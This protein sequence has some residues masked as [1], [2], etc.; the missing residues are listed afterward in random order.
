MGRLTFAIPAVIFVAIAAMFAIPFA[1]DLDPSKLPSALTDQPAP[2]FALPPVEG[3]PDSLGLSTADLHGQPSVVNVF[4]SWCLP[5]LAEHPIISRLAEEGVAVYGINH[6]DAAEDANRWLDR[7]G[8][9]YH[10][11]GADI[12]A[13]TSID[14]GVTGVPETFIVD[15]QGRVRHKIIGPMTPEIL[16]D[17]IMPLLRELNK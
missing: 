4:A 13:R 8:N 1:L 17:E 7:N 3:R 15:A 9:P 16:T 2:E 12:D 14:W 11:I 5:C 10:R 6:R